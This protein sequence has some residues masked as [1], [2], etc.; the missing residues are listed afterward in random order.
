MRFPQARRWDPPL[1][2]LDRDFAKLKPRTFSVDREATLAYKAV[3]DE[4][5][6]GVL[7][8]QIRGGY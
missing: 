5:F 1:Q 8:V 6:A 4:V 3:L 7:P 2:D